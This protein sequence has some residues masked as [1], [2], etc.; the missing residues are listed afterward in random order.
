MAT[1]SLGFDD[2]LDTRQIERAVA[3]IDRYQSMSC[4]GASAVALHRPRRFPDCNLAGELERQPTA[5]QDRIDRQALLIDP[6]RRG[7][8]R[9]LP[10]PNR[11]SL[12]FEPL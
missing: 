8:L 11:P 6:R 10:R 9:R 1:I 3:N 12:R 7:W 4:R 2:D 5:I